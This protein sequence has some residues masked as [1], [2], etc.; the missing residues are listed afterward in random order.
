MSEAPELSPEDQALLDRMANWVVDRGLETPA[1]LFLE[2]V[3]PLS[4][5][6][7]QGLV[8]LGPFAHALFST[9]DYDRLARLLEDRANLERLVRVIE[10]AADRRE[11]A[12]RA[13]R[14]AERADR[15][16]DDA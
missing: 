9:L 15:K 1:I 5:V 6:G 4:F 11:A 13:A 8:F 14:P 7:A 16:K 2:S 10:A 12:R 3:R